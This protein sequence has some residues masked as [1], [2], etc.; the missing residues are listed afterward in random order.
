MPFKLIL[1]S[2]RLTA[3]IEGWCWFDY[4]FYWSGRLLWWLYVFWSNF[5][6]YLL[7]PPFILNL[8]LTSAF[9]GRNTSRQDLLFMLVNFLLFPNH[10]FVIDYYRRRLQMLTSRYRVTI[11]CKPVEAKS[12]DLNLLPFFHNSLDSRELASDFRSPLLAVR[13]W[14]LKFISSKNAACKLYTNSPVYESVPLC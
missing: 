13:A 6:I 10:T 9:R 1:H 5:E 11:L 2:A 14:L 12:F 4:N 3:C 8:L 7:S